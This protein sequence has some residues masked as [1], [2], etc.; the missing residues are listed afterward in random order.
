MTFLMAVYRLA[1]GTVCFVF[2]WW[3]FD[4]KIAIAFVLMLWTIRLELE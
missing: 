4:P 3:A 2:L 1:V